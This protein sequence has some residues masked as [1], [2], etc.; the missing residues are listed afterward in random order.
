[1]LGAGPLAALMAA[2]R[3]ELEWG[4]ASS[5]VVAAPN[6][7]VACFSSIPAAEALSLQE[8]REPARQRGIVARLAFPNHER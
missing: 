2:E 4:R 3:A 8:R 5:R 1:M 7:S 6:A